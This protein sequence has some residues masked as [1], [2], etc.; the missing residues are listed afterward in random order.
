MKLF[1]RIFSMLV[2]A[3]AFS[4]LFCAPTFAEESLSISVDGVAEVEATPNTLETGTVDVYVTSTSRDGYK[5]SISDSDE[6]NALVSNHGN[7]IN[8][9]AESVTESNFT[10]NAWGVK[11]G[12]NFLPVPKLSDN[13][14]ELVNTAKAATN[15]KHTVT[16]GMKVDGTTTSGAYSSE[17][18]FT[19]VANPLVTHKTT[20]QKGH[21]VNATWKSLAKGDVASDL[22][23]DQAITSIQ[24]FTGDF[25]DSLRSAAQDIATA[26]SGWPVYTWFDN[27]TIYYYTEAD[28]VFFNADSSYMFYNM[29]KLASV[30]FNFGL[31][32]DV[33]PDRDGVIANVQNPVYITSEVTYMSSMFYNASS[34]TSL[35]ASNWDTSKVTDMSGMFYSTGL[36]TI[37]ASGWD[38]SSVT[39]MQYM[40]HNAASLTTLDTSKWDVSN[41]TKMDVMFSS[42]PSLTTLDVSKWDVSNV[43]SMSSMFDGASSITSLD[44]SKWNTGNVTDMS[45]MF[46]NMVSLATLDVSKWDTGK[47]TSM[48][49]MFSRASSLTSLDVSNW[50]TSSV[51]DMEGMFYRASSLTTLDVSKWDTSK[52]TD[53]SD[54][55]RTTSSLTSI[56]V[57]NWN[58]SSVTNMSAM[59]NV[60]SRLTSLDVSKWDTSKVTD[61]S[62]MFSGASSLTALDVSKWDVSNVTDMSSMFFN[63]SALT[64]LDLSKWDTSKVTSM[65]SMF[66]GAKA[67]TVLD[68]S[69][70]N[71]SKVTNMSSMFFAD[72][73]LVTIYASTLFDTSSVTG[74]NNMF[75][76]TYN[77]V[78]GNGT[79][80][81]YDHIDKEYARIDKPG[82]PGYFTEKR[83]AVRKATL[84]QGYEINDIWR[85]T[86]NADPTSIERF[87]GTFTDALQNAATNIAMSSSAYPVYTWNNGS[88]IYY[89]TEADEVY[90]NSNSSY[91][92][93]KLRNLRSIDFNFG[94][95]SDVDP[96]GD[97]YVG[98]ISEPVFITSNV[99]SMGSMFYYTGITTL[100]LSGMDTR[101]VTGMSEMFYG[102][103]SLTTIYASNLFNTNAV[104]DSSRMFID[105][106]NLIG[107]NG[108]TYNSSHTDKEYARIDTPTTPGYFTLKSN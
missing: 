55:F 63:N 60:A 64:S 108:T 23:V 32:T 83:R 20:L 91:M 76:N 62:R 74:S 1:S 85:F 14:L 53:M 50:D 90:L 16:F 70:W 98:F 99:T 5:L 59:F 36:A 67:L 77:I 31:E 42:A 81:S 97:G 26:D 69:G 56:D 73:S 34:L 27:G 19:A 8:P 28:E 7:S 82:T 3:F 75:I 95:E 72:E 105:A 4:V 18:V 65:M 49:Y 37:D 93:A 17:V 103:N 52:V 54:M 44:V 57:S 46:A 22:S 96:D 11:V 101:N 39:N 86:L 10:T 61:M 2:I 58:T 100:D 35:D 102:S 24:Q 94:L 15:E 41:V 12:D 79:T 43:V 88:T 71:T 45:S 106:T 89:Y 29:K 6:N 92:F 104:T 78:G 66:C 107:G 48:R 80:Y 33:D 25:T 13:V 51:T 9:L 40:F 47:V 30:D 68:L 87:T 84:K 21:I 38:T